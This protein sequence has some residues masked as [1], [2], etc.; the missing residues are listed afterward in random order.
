MLPELCV[1]LLRE[2]VILFGLT[3]KSWPLKGKPTTAVVQ[4]QQRPALES[5]VAGSFA[6]SVTCLIGDN[7]KTWLYVCFVLWVNVCVIK[8]FVRVWN[9]NLAKKVTD[10]LKCVFLTVI[11]FFTKTFQITENMY[12]SLMPVYWAKIMPVF[13]T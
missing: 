10:S 5:N 1:K 9:V 4:S 11:L 8:S 13:E 7:S 2:S 3:Y 12:C 6:F